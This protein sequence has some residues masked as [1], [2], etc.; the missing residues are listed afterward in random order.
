MEEVR[1]KECGLRGKKQSASQ[2]R[3][4]ASQDY[5]T[6]LTGGQLVRKFLSAFDLRESNKESLEPNF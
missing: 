6:S 5:I 3:S 4:F 1:V 2:H